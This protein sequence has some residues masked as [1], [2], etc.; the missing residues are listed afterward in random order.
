[1][2]P[3]WDS[4]EASKALETSQL[5]NFNDEEHDNRGCRSASSSCRCVIFPGL[6]QCRD[7]SDYDVFVKVIVENANKQDGGLGQ[8]KVASGSNKTTTG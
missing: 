8:C 3:T 6:S 2:K 1:L 4:L 5:V 7:D